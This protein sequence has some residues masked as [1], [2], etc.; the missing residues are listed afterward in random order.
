[1]RRM[2]FPHPRRVR[3]RSVSHPVEDVMKIV[4]ALSAAILVAGCTSSGGPA[5]SAR[6]QAQTARDEADLAAVLSGRIADPPQDCVD[7]R[8]LGGNKSYGREV[9][10]FSGRNDDVVYVNRLPAA[11]PG[12]NFGRRSRPGPPRRGFA[13]ATS[14]PCSIRPAAPNLAVAASARSRPTG[15]PARSAVPELGVSSR[16]ARHDSDPKTRCGRRMPARARA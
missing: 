8:D 5:P 11:C 16:P 14:S 2:A 3:R 10:V 6:A 4:I 1:M 13:A 15:G 9:I 7:Q 12:L